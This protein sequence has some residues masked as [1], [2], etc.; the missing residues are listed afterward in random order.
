V[1]GPTNGLTGMEKQKGGRAYKVNLPSFGCEIEGGNPKPQN[2]GKGKR[3]IRW[4]ERKSTLKG[5]VYNPKKTTIR[6]NA[7]GIEFFEEWGKE[8]ETT[9]VSPTPEGLRVKGGEEGPG[10]RIKDPVGQ[11]TGHDIKEGS[12]KWNEFARVQDP[13]KKEGQK[14]RGSWE[15]GGEGGTGE[16]GGD[17]EV[18]GKS[19][20]LNTG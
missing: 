5:R 17:E 9:D 2:R 14:R 20:E 1:S 16:E 11:R 6:T 4:L 10:L 18:C 15:S 8:K 13:H 12:K 7:S 19:R 3:K